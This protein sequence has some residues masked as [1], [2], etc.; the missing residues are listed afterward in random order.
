MDDMTQSP[1]TDPGTS[2]PSGLDRF[3][4]W[5]R[6]IDLRRA[7]DDKWL[8]GVCA[9][10]ARRL[11]VDPIAVRA[12][13]VL[14]V[15]LGGVGVTLYLV[16]WALLPNDKEQVLAERALRD[17]DAGGIVLLV[18]AALTLLGGVG[19]VGD[20]PGIDGIWWAVL[21]IAL[22]VWLVVRH[23]DGGTPSPT[24]V[25]QAQAA[26][27]YAA[28][29]AQ[30]EQVTAP[31]GPEAGPPPGPAAYQ[32][33]PAAGGH[34][35]P[36]GYQPPPAGWQPPQ[37]AIRPPKPP[38]RRSG[39]F[40]GVLLVSGLALAAYGV[41]QGLHESNHWVGSAQ[42]VALCAALGMFGLG[43]LV[44]GLLG[45]RAGFTGFLAVVL[46]L[47]TW[48]SSVLPDVDLGGGIGE[49][50]WR[51]AVS[52]TTSRYRLGIGEATL[53]L[54]DVSG[55]PATARTIEARVGLGELRILLPADATVEVRSSVGAGDIARLDPAYFDSPDA[56]NGSNGPDG[57]R[58]S[59][60][61]TFGTGTPVL[62][63]DAHVGVGQILIGKE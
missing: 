8:A 44:L 3:F 39:G 30:P 33:A 34:Q 16:A 27:A 38:R 31:A 7:G 22:V 24:Y 51:P 11:G 25:P 61:Q 5:I 1:A 52:D 21:P 28:G 46:A 63:V 14:L 40:V 13:L 59:T 36:G 43:V 47:A 4:G 55:T 35:P 58:I 2:P 18:A 62:V 12:V 10:I 6:S 41:T 42:T 56:L 57:R 48:T 26:P 20:V 54:S 15:V 32:P 45:R 9:G 49:R 29:P 60:V 17:G 23:R 37:P 53:D 50:T 19:F